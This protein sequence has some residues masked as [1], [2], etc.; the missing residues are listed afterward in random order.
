MT[1]YHAFIK[2]NIEKPYAA[3]SKKVALQDLSR[4]IPPLIGILL[5]LLKKENIKTNAD[6]F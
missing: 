2:E 6:F 5:N 1:K 4:E 3:I